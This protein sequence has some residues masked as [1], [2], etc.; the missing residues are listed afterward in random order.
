[1]GCLI[2]EKIKKLQA[3]SHVMRP[4]VSYNINPAFDKYYETY[5]VISADG[6]TTD[7]G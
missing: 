6:V 3:I 4:S 1:M 7:R 2:L 5:E